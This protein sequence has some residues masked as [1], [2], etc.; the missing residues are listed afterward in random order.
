MPDKEI[1]VA[2]TTDNKE[3]VKKAAVG[4]AVIEEEP[5][6][7]VEEEEEKP[8][9]E[10]TD[11]KIEEEKEEEEEG[12]TEEE[13]AEEDSDEEES[14]EEEE[15]PA[16]K[17]K[18]KGKGYLKRINKLTKDK[19]KLS[20]ENR[21]LRERLEALEKDK[22]E[23]K[24]EE[25]K[26]EQQAKTLSGK[27][28]PQRGDFQ[29]YDDYMEALT[30]WKYEERK[31]QEKLDADKQVS[32]DRR[33]K[34]FDDYQGHVKEALEEYD[35]FDDV[36]TN[37]KMKIPNAVLFA[38]MEMENGPH[39]AYYLGKNPDVC[40]DL[41]SR[42]DLSAVMEAGRISDYITAVREG[43][44]TPEGE[45][46]KAA[47]KAEEKKEEKKVVSRAPSPITP[48]GGSAKTSIPDIETMPYDQ[49]KKLRAAG[50][51]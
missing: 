7:K 45:E 46:I 41:M 27:P 51:I 48:V 24:P 44:I 15:K 28:K 37:S 43:K 36:V 3:D 33:K 2:S 42:T 40:A 13:E 20:D 4:T 23:K 47:P 5:K 49:Y 30:D 25:K 17:E 39:V 32:E 34:I 11:K 19:Y 14:E 8:K 1:K 21:E 16:A 10:E 26:P 12:E 35:D 18:P 9:P 31:A 6:P 29:S 22:E 50:K 38:I